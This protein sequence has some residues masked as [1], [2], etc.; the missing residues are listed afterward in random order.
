MRLLQFVWLLGQ[1]D[2]LHSGQCPA[3]NRCLANDA[4]SARAWKKIQTDETV[5]IK[6][7]LSKEQME[8]LDRAK[9]L[10]SHALPGATFA[11]VIT[12][13]AQRYV[14]QQTGVKFRG[15]S[16]R[17]SEYLWETDSILGQKNSFWVRIL[18]VSLRIQG[19]ERFAGQNIFSRLTISSLGLPA[20]GMSFKTWDRFAV[21][22]ISIVTQPDV[23]SIIW[24][25]LLGRSRRASNGGFQGR[26]RGPWVMDDGAGT[27]HSVLKFLDLILGERS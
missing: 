18:G 23:D 27:F 20:E 6:L 19:L 2:R 13:L 3:A 12:S 7:T 10:L 24:F 4:A 17:H 26:P 11:E 9:E 22:T 15:G 8:I 14:K 25:F 5:R 21:A 16:Q 1:W